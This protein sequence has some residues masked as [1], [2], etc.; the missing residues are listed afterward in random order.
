MPQ[1]ILPLF[2]DDVTP[3]TIMAARPNFPEGI[4]LASGCAYEA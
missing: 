3:I 1:A 4:R 2:P